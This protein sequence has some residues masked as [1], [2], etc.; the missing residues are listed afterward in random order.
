MPTVLPLGSRF[1]PAGFCSMNR[2]RIILNPQYGL[3]RTT[4]IANEKRCA[5]LS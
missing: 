3:A 2:W 4:L 5:L 1:G